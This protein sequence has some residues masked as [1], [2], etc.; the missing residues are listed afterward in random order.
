MNLCDRKLR[1][2]GLTDDER[3][4]HQQRAQAFEKGVPTPMVNSH[5]NIS[6][7]AMKASA[8]GLV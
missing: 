6:M 8:K 7:D 2:L 1:S 4:R 5:S 3:D